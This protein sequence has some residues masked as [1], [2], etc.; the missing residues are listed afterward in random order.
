VDW[1]RLAQDRDQWGVL[2]NTVINHRIPE[3]VRSFL[4]E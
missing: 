4:T 1:I 3:K 2:V